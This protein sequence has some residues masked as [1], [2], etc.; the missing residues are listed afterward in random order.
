MKIKTGVAQLL[1]TI[2]E[3]VECF[4]LNSQGHCHFQPLAKVEPFQDRLVGLL[5]EI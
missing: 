5:G 2:P 1:D 3:F 4:C